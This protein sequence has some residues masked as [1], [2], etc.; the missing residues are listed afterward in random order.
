MCISGEPTT[1]VVGFVEDLFERP[2][3]VNRRIPVAAQVRAFNLLLR[4]PGVVDPGLIV[5]AVPR[6]AFR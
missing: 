6:S 1:L 5:V 4:A 2:Q 3:E